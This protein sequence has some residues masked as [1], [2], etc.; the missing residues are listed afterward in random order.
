MLFASLNKVTQNDDGSCTVVGI[1]SSPSRDSQGE[2]VVPSAI[3]EA[4]QE[5]LK[6]PTVRSMHKAVPVGKT[7]GM[8]ILPDNSTRIVIAQAIY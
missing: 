5:Y 7:I 1:A 6:Y 8:Q 4:A 2:I 3:M